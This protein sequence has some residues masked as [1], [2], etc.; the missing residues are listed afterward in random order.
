M[1]PPVAPAS[2]FFG[3]FPQTHA[4]SLVG[5]GKTA[6]TAPATHH[7]SHHFQLSTGMPF[8]ALRRLAKHPHGLS[9]RLWRLPLFDST[10]LNPAMSSA[11]SAT[12]CFSRPTN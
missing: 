5:L 11:C 2:P 3:Q 4:Q 6:L 9:P 12:N 1:Q 7:R 10:A 8:R